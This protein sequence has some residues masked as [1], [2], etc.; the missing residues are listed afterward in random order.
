[1]AVRRTGRRKKGT[2]RDFEH[3]LDPE[4]AAAQRSWEQLA[5]RLRAHERM[6]VSALDE[7][8]PAE[9]PFPYQMF[10]DVKAARA[11]CN[12]AFHHLMDLIE[13]RASGSK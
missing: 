4:L 12:A 7:H 2:M 13:R 11:K 5:H 10:S 3:S 6:L 1:M 9:K 8:T